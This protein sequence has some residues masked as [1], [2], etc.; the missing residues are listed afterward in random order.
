M[1]LTDWNWRHPVELQDVAWDCAA[2]SA[3]W[4]LQA[5]GLAYPEADVVAGLGAERISPAWGLLDASGAGL[6]A[7]LAEIGVAASN[8]PQASWQEMID[9]AGYQPMVMGGRQWCHW[10]GVR[11]APAAFG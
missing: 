7:Y 9:A 6:V 3:A 10:S 4:V 1:A 8:N 5:A 2:A 11:M